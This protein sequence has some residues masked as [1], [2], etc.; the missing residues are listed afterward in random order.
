ME[1]FQENQNG[2]FFLVLVIHSCC[3]VKLFWELT[4]YWL[5]LLY[6]YA[7]PYFNCQKNVLKSVETIKIMA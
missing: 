5:S 7:S 4:Y 3:I 1:S 6:L 2:I